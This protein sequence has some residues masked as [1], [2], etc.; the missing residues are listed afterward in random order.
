MKVGKPV[1]FIPFFM[2]LLLG[3]SKERLKLKKIFC[4]ITCLIICE[5]YILSSRSKKPSQPT[6]QLIN[7]LLN[8]STSLVLQ[9]LELKADMI[10]LLA[11][12]R[13]FT[14]R[15]LFRTQ[16]NINNEAFLQ[17]QITTFNDLKVNDFYVQLGSKFA[18]L[19]EVHRARLIL[20][21]PTANFYKSGDVNVYAA[22]NRLI[23]TRQ[24][25]LQNSVFYMSF[26]EGLSQ[27]TSHEVF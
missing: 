11:R 20:N 14:S 4:S 16:S 24:F 26:A 6:L 12:P 22:K 25:F 5:M 3:L 23:K 1:I 17:K 10:H 19:L 7:T 27:S 8:D 13:L 15:C 18:Q 21:R 9:S 2:L